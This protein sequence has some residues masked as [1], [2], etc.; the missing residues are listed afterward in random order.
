[1]ELTPEQLIR[2]ELS[3]R[4]ADPEFARF[5]D[6]LDRRA[7]GERSVSGAPLLQAGQPKPQSAASLFELLQRASSAKAREASFRSRPLASLRTRERPAATAGRVYHRDSDKT[8]CNRVARGRRMPRA[9]KAFVLAAS[10]PVALALLATAFILAITL[11]DLSRLTQNVPLAQVDSEYPRN[12]LVVRIEHSARSVALIEARTS[13]SVPNEPVDA[14]TPDGCEPDESVSTEQIVPWNDNASNESACSVAFTLDP[15]VRPPSDDAPMAWAR[16]NPLS[17]FADAAI[18][19]A[20]SREDAEYLGFTGSSV[21]QERLG[22]SLI[23]LV[24]QAGGLNRIALAGR[25]EDTETS[26]SS[27]L[28]ALRGNLLRASILIDYSLRHAP[29][30]DG[31]EYASQAASNHGE[32]CLVQLSNLLQHAESQ[33]LASAE[34]P[35]FKSGSEGFD[36]TRLCIAQLRWAEDTDL[37]AWVARSNVNTLSLLDAS[38]TPSARFRVS[39]ACASVILQLLA[40]HEHRDPLAIPDLDSIGIADLAA[41]NTSGS[42]YS[43]MHFM[44]GA[45]SMRWATS[46][47]LFGGDTSELFAESGWTDS[48]ACSL[49]WR[50]FAQAEHSS[51]TLVPSHWYWNPSFAYRYEQTLPEGISYC[52]RGYSES[53]ESFGRAQLEYTTDD[54][55]PK[56]VPFIWRGLLPPAERDPSIVLRCS[57]HLIF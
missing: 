29:P 50:A 20:D 38:E 53:S 10:A 1:M 28:I 22:I 34:R 36:R 33:A 24:N 41:A 14:V 31:M 55:D 8:G 47:A 16:A 9:R 3:L 57:F 11:G 18:G 12:D 27:G 56:L 49:Q 13:D 54:A 45:W 2:L 46:D 44:D 39:Q 42:V 4:K 17:T 37:S 51:D 30:D 48:L 52:W 40:A 26:I 35:A 25:G 6:E 19:D 5:M 7:S 15:L 32:A 21:D 43:L 23:E